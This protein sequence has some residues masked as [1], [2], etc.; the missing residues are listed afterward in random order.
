ML[1]KIK[2]IA[3]LDFGGT[4]YKRRMEHEARLRGSN[5]YR[6]LS[7]FINGLVQLYVLYIFFREMHLSLEFLL[8]F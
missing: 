5:E 7:I 2:V 3:L 4:L 8:T 6:W 1:I